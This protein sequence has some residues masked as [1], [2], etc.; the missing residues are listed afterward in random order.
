MSLG[1]PVIDADGHVW[2]PI[3]L[4]ER[5]IDPAYQHKAPRTWP[6]AGQQKRLEIEGE[7][8]PKIDGTNPSPPIFWEYLRKLMESR[9][10]EGV[11]RAFP[12]DLYLRDLDRE[13]IDQVVLFPTLGLIVMGREY[14][15]RGLAAAV[16]QAYNNWLAEYCSYAPGR[17]LGAAMIALHD[18][19]AAVV[20]ARRAV[21]ELGMRTLFL[22]PNPL[23][24]RT[25]DDPAY[26]PFYAEVERLG[27]P[28]AIHEGGGSRLPAAGGDRFKTHLMSHL[29]SHP[30]EQ[31]LALESL[32]FGGVFERF[33]KL[34]AI[35]LESGC[36]WLPYWLDRMDEHQ[37]Y[38]GAIEAPELTMKPSDYFRRQCW[39]ST[40]CEERGLRHVIDWIGDD[41]IVFASD[42][43]HPDGKFPDALSNF[44]E[45]PGVSAASKRKILCDNA[46]K[47]Y[48]LAGQPAPIR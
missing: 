38:L 31:M 4:W 40:E 11:A 25:L 16:A 7:A 12:P 20:E 2:E 48:H 9:H 46:L 47:L 28:I 35:F 8:M 22:R 23:Y 29:P 36:G 18:L 39:I 17:L 41:Q 26:D 15:D 19:D 27:V 13:G 33:P 44:L 30:F 21:Q 34:E 43:P 6:G 32:I 24:G 3:D 42:Y 10:P 5:F 37:E 1:Y 14:Q 45:L